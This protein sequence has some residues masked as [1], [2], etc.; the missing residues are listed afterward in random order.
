MVG[1]YVTAW[2]FLRECPRLDNRLRTITR[3]RSRA[4]EER[5]INGGGDALA[6]SSH[7]EYSSWKIRLMTFKL[8]C[9][10]GRRPI[11]SSGEEVLGRMRAEE[12]SKKVLAGTILRGHSTRNVRVGIWFQDHCIKNNRATGTLEG[13]SIVRGGNAGEDAGGGE[14]FGGGEVCVG[15]G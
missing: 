3:K 4:E 15:C 2:L 5:W 11:R 12:S 13:D 8:G 14:S 7:I 10:L 9:S 1:P 6:G